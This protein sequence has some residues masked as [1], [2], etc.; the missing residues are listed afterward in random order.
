MA[1]LLALSAAIAVSFCSCMN[2]NMLMWDDDEWSGGEIQDGERGLSNSELE[3]DDYD[4]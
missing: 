3:I 2:P 4:R 1:L